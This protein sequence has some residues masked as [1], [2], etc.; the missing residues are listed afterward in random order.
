MEVAEKGLFLRMV[1]FLKKQREGFLRRLP[2][3]F[4]F[5]SHQ[6]NRITCLLLAAREADKMG[7]WQRRM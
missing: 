6:P 3:G 4:P 2:A 1:L 7:T 5:K